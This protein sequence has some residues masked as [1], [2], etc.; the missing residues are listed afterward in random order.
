M[1]CTP[2]LAHA[3]EGFVVGWTAPQECPSSEEL[4]RRTALRVL[5]DATLRARGT[6]ERLSGKYR[7]VLEV[8]SAAFHGERTL[9]AESCDDLATSTAVVIA[10]SAVPAAITVATARGGSTASSSVPSAPSPAITPSPVTLPS[11]VRSSAPA[12]DHPSLPTSKPKLAVTRLQARFVVDAGLLPTL[13]AGGEMGLGFVFRTWLHVEARVGAFASQSASLAADTSRGATF[14]MVSGG[15][16]ACASLTKRFEIAP[17]LGVDVSHLASQGF[18]AS[19]TSAASST[20]VSP[21]GGVR[22]YAPINR[23][24]GVSLG[25]FARVPLGRQPFIITASGV[26]HEPDFVAFRGDFG[27]EVH[28]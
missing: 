7:V 28:F 11:A 10:M 2:A 3:R 21:E 20:L 12:A 8:E 15:A 25:A 24:L 5:A 1:S 18:G 23:W 4:A 9:E 6:V 14:L 17:C 26:V 27:P 13:G 22:L 19:K 16:R